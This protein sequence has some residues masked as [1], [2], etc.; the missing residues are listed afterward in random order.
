[1]E[2]NAVELK[3]TVTEFCAEPN[4][5]NRR[6]LEKKKNLSSQIHFFLV[7]VSTSCTDDFNTK[8]LCLISCATH[9]IVKHKSQFLTFL[10]TSISGLIVP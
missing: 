7:Y 5:C 1:M 6:G 3:N 10:V 9:L 8:T 4:P 2:Q